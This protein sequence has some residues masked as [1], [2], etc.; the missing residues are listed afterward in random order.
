MSCLERRPQLGASVSRGS[1]VLF[2]SHN[3]CS[4]L[5]Q[6]HNGGNSCGQWKTSVG[7]EDEIIGLIIVHMLIKNFYT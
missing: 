5:S 7:L 2:Y 6:V 1:T 4:P 3:N